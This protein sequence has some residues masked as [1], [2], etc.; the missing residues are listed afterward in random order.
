MKKFFYLLLA[1]AV[2]FGYT[3]IASAFSIGFEGDKPGNAPSIPV[4]TKAEITGNVTVETGSGFTPDS[5]IQATEGDNLL[6]LSTGSAGT[7]PGPAL[8]SGLSGPGVVDNE[9]GRIP[10]V[11]E[12]DAAIWTLAFTG[13]G[14]LSFDFDFLTNET[15]FFEP[16]FPDL[17]EISLDG[18][19]IS[20]GVFEVIDDFG[21]API[22]TGD[23]P[24]ISED[25]FSQI[26]IRGP[27]GT[28][29]QTGRLGWNI[30]TAK[31]AGSGPHLLEFFVADGNDSLN[32]SALLVD[33]IQLSKGAPVPE[34]A[35]MLLVGVGLLGLTGAGR[36]GNFMK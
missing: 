30:I 32:D 34:P 13:E 5:E 23:F 14:L 16:A 3:E 8:L 36:R 4:G 19:S 10:G 29:F 12:F 17:Y 25:Q 15:N 6:Y 28:I 2:S 26:P 1:L 21:G 9:L 24:V 11:T 33:N 7:I 31:V 35:T 22:D 20:K 18:N 27:D